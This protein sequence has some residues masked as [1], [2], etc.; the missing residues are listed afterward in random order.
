VPDPLAEKYYQWSP[1]NYVGNNPIIRI[2]PN[3]EDWDVV[4]NHE[5]KTITIRADFTAIKGKAGIQ[6]AAANWNAQSGKFN[7]I[8][9]KGKDAIEYSVNFDIQVN[10]PDENIAENS[11]QIAPDNAKIFE[12]RIETNRDG[13]EVI[14]TP[15]GASD[16]RNFAVRESQKENSNVIGHEMGHNLGMTHDKGLMKE[17]IGGTRLSKTNVKETLGFSGIGKGRA[18]TKSNAEMI[19]KQVIGTS[20]QGFQKGKLKYNENWKKND[21]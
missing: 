19:S 9:G 4:L 3:G 18:G 12:P 13:D 7:Y 16:G 10:S 1:Y 20:P 5:D 15:Q 14:I 11:M 6:Q 2:D 17:N 21:F 8:V